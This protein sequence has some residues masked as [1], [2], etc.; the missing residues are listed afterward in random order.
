M[1]CGCST[2]AATAASPTRQTATTPALAR[3]AT[4]SA[5]RGSVT[6]CRA[7]VP[8]TPTTTAGRRGAGGTTPAGPRRW[9]LAAVDAGVREP[10]A[11]ARRGSHNRGAGGVTCEVPAALQVVR[12]R[13]RHR[14]SDRAGPVRRLFR[15]GL[16]RM[17]DAD[18]RP[19]CRVGRLVPG[20]AQADD[21]CSAVP[22][23]LLHERHMHVQEL[24]MNQPPGDTVT[25]WCACETS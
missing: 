9:L 4:W 3:T 8:A 6:R 12:M 7:G 18:R 15:V 17:R 24:L 20:R 5:L 13:A 1:T 19:A 23:L 21:C 25:Y 22:E 16:P 10:R 11:V 14:Q 2:C